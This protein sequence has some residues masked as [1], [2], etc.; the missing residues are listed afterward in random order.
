M[1]QLSHLKI[2]KLLI[3]PLKSNKIKSKIKLNIYLYPIYLTILKNKKRK[4]ARLKLLKKKSSLT[5]ILKTGMEMKMD[6]MRFTKVLNL[7]VKH[8]L[9]KT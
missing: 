8:R 5:K 4:M 6:L 9:R 2:L 7:L 1:K 3:T